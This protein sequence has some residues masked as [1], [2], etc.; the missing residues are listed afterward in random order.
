MKPIFIK[1]MINFAMIQTV[2]FA[3]SVNVGLQLPISNGILSAIA[4]TWFIVFAISFLPA[5][6]VSFIFA[7]FSK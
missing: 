6:I 4:F 5:V 1:A 7:Y 2:I 3:A